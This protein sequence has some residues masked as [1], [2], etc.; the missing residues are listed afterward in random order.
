MDNDASDN[1]SEAFVSSSSSKE[2]TIYSD[3]LSAFISILLK[4]TYNQ[5][6]L[7]IVKEIVILKYNDMSLSYLRQLF[8]DLDKQKSIE[9]YQLL[10]KYSDIFYINNN[11]LELVSLIVKEKYKNDSVFILKPSLT[12]IMEHNVYKL[13]IDDKLY[14]VPL[15]HSE[16][17]FD[18]PDGSEIIVLCQPKLPHGITIDENNNIYYDKCIKID[19]ELK[20]LIEGNNFVSI[21]VG[22]KWFLIPL[23]KLQIKKE[24]IFI[25]KE[26]GIPQISEKD[27]YSVSYKSDIIVKIILT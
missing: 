25:L 6:F 10:Y 1:S 3:I 5:L 16:L 2:S 23:N 9:L 27:M 12:D 17:Y 7:H 13:Y 22:E 26:Q 14:L 24:Q 8:Q 18:A 11:I 15:W 20:Q 19:S 21:D 4:G